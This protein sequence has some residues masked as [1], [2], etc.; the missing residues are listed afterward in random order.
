MTSSK[1]SS[2]KYRIRHP[3]ANAKFATTFTLRT[4]NYLDS[5]EN[6]VVAIEWSSSKVMLKQYST[7]NKLKN[8]VNLDIIEQIKFQ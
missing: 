4:M 6:F 7:C 5:S 2:K 8:D 1:M 3:N